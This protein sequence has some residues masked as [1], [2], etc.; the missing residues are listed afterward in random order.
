MNLHLKIASA[1]R[2]NAKGASSD[3]PVIYCVL[4]IDRYMC[5]YLYQNGIKYSYLYKVD[6]YIVLDV[7]W[8]SAF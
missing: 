5:N 3:P 8:L 4:G 6:K 7:K 2:I 1:C